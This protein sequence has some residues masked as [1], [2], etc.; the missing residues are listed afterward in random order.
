[1]SSLLRLFYGSPPSPVSHPG[2]GLFTA[3]PV[4]ADVCW[5][6]ARVVDLVWGTCSYTTPELP[7]AG[8]C[9]ARG[10]CF[11]GR[12][13]CAPGATSAVGGGCET[14]TVPPVCKVFKT[15]YPVKGSRAYDADRC[16]IHPEYGSAVIPSKRWLAAQAAEAQLWRRGGDTDSHAE[17][18]DRQPIRERTSD[19]ARD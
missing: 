18:G 17:V 2:S 10:V 15:K 4:Q 1:M 11:F 16:L 3:S 8:G 5:S 7:C 12:C 14:T 9:G 6:P 13:R 19:E